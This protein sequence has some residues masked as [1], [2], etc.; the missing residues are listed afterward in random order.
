MP[1]FWGVKERS[2]AGSGESNARRFLIE[3]DLVEAIIAVPENMFYNTGIGTFIWILS[4]RKE[5]RRKGKIQL[6]DATAMKS[7]LRRNM[8]K[9]NCAFT[10]EI[11]QEILRLFLE[12]EESDTSRIFPNEEFGYWSITVERPL[13]L[14]VHPAR[15]IPA[16][17]FRREE[18]RTAILEAVTRAAKEAPLDDWTKRRSSRPPSSRNSAPSSRKRM[19]R[20]SPSQASRTRRCATARSSPCATR[21]A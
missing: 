2:D 17:I 10:P 7:P 12:M 21:A 9:K 19:K 13:R 16:A 8:G 5:E 4:N 15:E 6:I 20:H 1:R 14:R 3:N 18:E 11:R